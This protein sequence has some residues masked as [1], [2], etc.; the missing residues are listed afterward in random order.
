MSTVEELPSDEWQAGR[1]NANASSPPGGVVPSILILY[2]P[3]V[4]PSMPFGA[5][6]AFVH[7]GI[8]TEQ[9]AAGHQ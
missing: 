7:G 9:P 5:G 1:C 2:T 4:L 8:V 3:L 6:L